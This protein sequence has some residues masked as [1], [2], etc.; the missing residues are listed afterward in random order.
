MPL[1]GSL[2]QAQKHIRGSGTFFPASGQ[3]AIAMA[4]QLLQDPERIVRDAAVGAI[5]EITA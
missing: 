5:E 1:Q 2:W 4:T 3:A